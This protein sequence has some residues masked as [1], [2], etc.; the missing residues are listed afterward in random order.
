[1]C[2]AVLLNSCYHMTWVDTIGSA[3]RHR[4]RNKV[5][6]LVSRRGSVLE[7]SCDSAE[8]SCHSVCHSAQMGVTL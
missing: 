1:M 4:P 8:C 2:N 6:A 7:P 3:L 5:V